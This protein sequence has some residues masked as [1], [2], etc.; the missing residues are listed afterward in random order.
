MWERECLLLN[1]LAWK[2]YTKRQK[3]N[4]EAVA[5][6]LGVKVILRFSLKRWQRVKRVSM[7]ET[8]L[9]TALMQ[10]RTNE[11][12]LILHF[13]QWF[14]F[15]RSRGRRIR[16]L[17]KCWDNW[18]MCTYQQKKE[19]ILFSDAV[20][21]LQLVRKTALISQWRHASRN[22]LKRSSYKGQR[23]IKQ[24][25]TPR[26]LYLVSIWIHDCPKLLLMSCWRM[27]RRH[28]LSTKGGNEAK[29]SKEKGSLQTLRCD[30]N[31]D[32]SS[33]SHVKTS[34]HN[35]NE[36]VE[37]IPA[38]EKDLSEKRKELMKSVSHIKMMKAKKVIAGGNLS[39]QKRTLKLYQR[40]IDNH[41]CICGGNH[42]HHSDSKSTNYHE[43][44][45][46]EECKILKMKK[47]VF[48]Y[49]QQSLEESSMRLRDLNE[50]I[51]KVGEKNAKAGLAMNK[52]LVSYIECSCTVSQL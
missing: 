42:L 6:Y 30:D 15:S 4:V 13:C 20:R 14:D 40:D 7:E 1:F 8:N 16:K 33:V 43:P 39:V 46:N 32:N 34:R 3:R 41:C 45:R 38:A 11:L 44:Y 24:C 49:L 21:T 27:W 47:R 25:T 48:S 9:K 18:F 22:L 31:I 37:T 19:R 17:R 29:T 5:N 12:C 51:E 23:T 52:S 2:K 36:I 35:S 50:T 26:T 28:Q 10:K